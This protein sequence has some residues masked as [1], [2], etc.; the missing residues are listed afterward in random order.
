MNEYYRDLIT[1]LGL[2]REEAKK[3]AQSIYVLHK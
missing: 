1:N 2:K 3:I